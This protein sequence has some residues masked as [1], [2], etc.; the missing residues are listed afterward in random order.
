MLRAP[1][2][3]TQAA[4]RSPRTPTRSHLGPSKDGGAVGAGAPPQPAGMLYA[5]AV[6]APKSA[7][8]SPR[9]PT[10]S[11][12]GPSTDG[13]VE[14]STSVRSGDWL[15]HSLALG[16][17]V[18]QEDGTLGVVCDGPDSDSSYVDA[19][20]ELATRVRVGAVVKMRDKGDEEWG[21]GFVT[22]LEPLL[23]TKCLTDGPSAEGY[24]YD[25]VRAVDLL[26]E[27][28]QALTRSS[29]GLDVRMLLEDGS[30]TNNIKASTLARPSEAELAAAPWLAEPRLVLPRPPVSS[31]WVKAGTVL[32]ASIE[33]GV[34]C[35][36]PDSGG[37]V[38][39]LLEDGSISD[40]IKASALARPSETELAA[41]PWHGKS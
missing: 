10:R 18:R 26:L 9:T 13:A 16:D 27:D 40:Y 11:H 29:A 37:E 39:L 24:S 2:V 8:R 30:T 33:L 5:P 25:E 12:P 14:H 17:A 28:V 3:G 38:R 19:M 35:Y 32:R 15:G 36:G 34:V 31:G 21:R 1:P 7:A 6:W 20:R 4:A 41:A 22:S 23:V